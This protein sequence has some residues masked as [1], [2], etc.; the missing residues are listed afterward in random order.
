MMQSSRIEIFEDLDQKVPEIL[1]VSGNCAHTTFLTLENA[2][3]LD[4]GAILKAL[5]PFPGLRSG[6]KPVEPS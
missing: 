2:F 3:K 1:A 4:G 6:V 5:T